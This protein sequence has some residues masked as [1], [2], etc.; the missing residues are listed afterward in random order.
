[1]GGGVEHRL[2]FLS[3]SEGNHRWEDARGCRGS[4]WWRGCLCLGVTMEIVEMTGS[5][6][7]PAPEKRRV[8]CICGGTQLNS[9]EVGA[10]LEASGDPWEW[11]L[12]L[13]VQPGVLQQG[14]SPH[15]P[16]AWGARFHLF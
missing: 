10:T 8:C 5:L 11:L 3:R 1:M 7:H 13:P 4:S 2:Y 14:E 9:Q 15:P 16:L 6:W 12:G